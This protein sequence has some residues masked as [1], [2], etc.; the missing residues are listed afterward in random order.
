M[1]HVIAHIYTPLTFPRHAFFCMS[2]MDMN[3]SREVVFHT[4]RRPTN[5]LK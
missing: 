4:P 1:R 2:K 5:V 3:L